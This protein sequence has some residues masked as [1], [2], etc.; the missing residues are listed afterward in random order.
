MCL[1]VRILDKHVGLISLFS[2]E[3]TR[4]GSREIHLWRTVYRLQGCVENKV[5][6]QTLKSCNDTYISELFYVH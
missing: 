3:F 5:L 2:R 4:Y 1:K 6:V